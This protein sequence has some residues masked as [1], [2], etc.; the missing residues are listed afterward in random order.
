MPR[1]NHILCLTEGDR[2]AD[3]TLARAMLLAADHQARLTV[4]EVLEAVGWQLRLLPGAPPP[5]DIDRARRDACL[6]ALR[7]KVADSGGGDIAVKVAVGNNH[8]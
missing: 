7:R 6:G 5:E 1:F 2:Q 3:A 8:V 4:L